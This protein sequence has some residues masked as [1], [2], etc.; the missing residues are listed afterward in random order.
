[1]AGKRIAYLNP[2]AFQRLIDRR[3][4]KR[5]VGPDDD[6]VSPGPVA[7]NHGEEHLVPPV[8]TVHV[9]RPERGGEAGAVQIEDE[10]RM[11]ADG[12]EVAVVGRLL[13]RAVNWTSRTV[14]VD[15]HAPGGWPGGLVHQ[16]R[17]EPR[18]ALIVPLLREDFRFEPV[19]R[20]GKR[21]AALPPLTRA[22]HPK[23][24]ILG[25]PLGVVRVLIAGQAAVDRLAKEVGPGEPAIASG[26]RI[27]EVPLDQ[28]AQAEALAQLAG[29]QQA[30]I[31][32]HRRAPELHAELRVER[33]LDRARFRVTHRVVPS[34]SAR[35]P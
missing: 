12:L 34:A 3:E 2:P 10:Q 33:Q 28:R 8:R 21:D 19:E 15:G 11:I 7:V 24:G 9:A 25:Q 23:R 17:V 1:L 35:N 29:E 6:A 27:G 5:R 14:D 18:E 31:G 20:R 22:Q 16:V 26:A 4:G 13:L 30:G 32:G